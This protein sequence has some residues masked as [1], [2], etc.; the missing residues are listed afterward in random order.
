MNTV[1]SRISSSN[2]GKD[3][4]GLLAT[5]YDYLK[6]LKS[7]IEE[8]LVYKFPLA[9]MASLS[10]IL[11]VI[12]GLLEFTHL[13]PN[14]ERILYTSILPFLERT[15]KWRYPSVSVNSLEA[16]FDRAACKRNRTTRKQT[17]LKQLEDV[18]VAQPM[19]PPSDVQESLGSCI[20]KIRCYQST[21]DIGVDAL[22]MRLSGSHSQ[23]YLLQCAILCPSVKILDLQGCT[24]LDERTLDAMVAF[25]NKVKYVFLK[26][27]KISEDSSLVVKELRDNRK[28]IVDFRGGRCRC[29]GHFSL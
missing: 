8:E 10:S 11:A 7:L 2:M 13:S 17:F 14:E 6:V 20:A 29:C 5:S 16:L 1:P 12:T 28:C 24:N 19:Q 27:T 9:F 23:E 3:D 18:V 25:C 21:S 26:R 22:R 15:W 4:D